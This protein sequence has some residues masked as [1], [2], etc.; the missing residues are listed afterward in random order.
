MVVVEAAAITACGV[1][2]Y[3][4]GKE[5]TIATI[6]SVKMKL[7]LS[8]KEQSNKE[9]YEQRKQERKER[10]AK[11]NEYRNSITTKNDKNGGVGGGL[12][13]SFDWKSDGSNQKKSSTSEGWLGK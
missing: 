9:T 4:G 12:A 8:T 3:K 6:K 1:A 11:V 13:P 2:A 7:R 5:A 10:F